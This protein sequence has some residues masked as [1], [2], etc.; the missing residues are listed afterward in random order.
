VCES[1]FFNTVATVKEHDPNVD[2]SDVQGP[3]RDHKGSIRFDGGLAT[4][5]EINYI[6]R[7]SDKRITLAKI[8]SEE[9]VTV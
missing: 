4:N 1:P 9:K 6:I 8:K 7:P 2:P 5:A 3:I